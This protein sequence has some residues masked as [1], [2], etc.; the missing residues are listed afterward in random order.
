MNLYKGSSL[1]PP[2]PVDEMQ[3]N[4]S[5]WFM[6][7]ILSVEPESSSYIYES[8]KMIWENQKCAAQFHRIKI[9]CHYI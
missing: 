1:I 8:L 4:F 5:T 2:F 7:F 9:F 6:H 3:T